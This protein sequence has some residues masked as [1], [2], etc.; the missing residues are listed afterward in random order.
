M[1]A[2]LLLLA[3]NLAW[4][5][6][7]EPE[8][9]REAA[10]RAQAAGDCVEARRIWLD[11][12]AAVGDDLEAWKGIA[13]CR[14]GGDI[15]AF[16]EGTTEAI[17][18]SFILRHVPMALEQLQL[19]ELVPILSR[20]QTQE[21]KGI[22]DYLL[23]T[24]LHRRMN[25]PALAL[26]AMGQAISLKPDDA[27]LRL[28][29]AQL[30][31]EQGQ[32]GEARAAYREAVGAAAHAPRLALVYGAAMGWPAPFLLLCLGLAAAALRV[33]LHQ[34]QQ[35]PAPSPLA[36][37]PL[38]GE[39]HALVEAHAMDPRHQRQI[40]GLALLVGLVC[41]VEFWIAGQRV[42][43]VALLAAGSAGGLWLASVPLRRPLTRL[44]LDSAKLVGAVATGRIYRRLSRI[45]LWGQ[46]AVLLACAL[47]VVFVTPRVEQG[48]LRLAALFLLSMLFFASL[49]SLMLTV[50]AQSASL[51]SSLRG[52]AIAGTLPFLVLFLYLERRSL[53]HLVASGA[54]LDPL[55][56]ERALAY[57][58]VWGTA[59][60]LALMM[61][62]ILSRSI[63]DPLSAIDAAVQRVRAGD[64]QARPEVSRRDEIGALATAVGDMAEGLAQRE[65]IK[66][67]FRRYVD[68]RVAEH[69]MADEAGMK[70]GRRRHAAV[71]F[72]DVRGFTSLSEQV[73]PEVVVQVLN[74]VFTRLTPVVARWGGVVDKFIGDAMMAVWGVPEPVREG[75]LA[76]LPLEVL[77][78]EA[79][80]DMLTA[81]D[82]L[83][84]ELAARDLPQL[85]LG[86]GVNSGRVIAG[87]IGS[88]ERQEYTVIGDVVNT[89]QRAEGAARDLGRLLVTEAIVDAVGER[90]ELVEVEAQT[91]K[92][93]AGKVRLWRVEGRR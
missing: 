91:L 65:R 1:L 67:T 36:S 16:L 82:A 77:A 10:R 83:N 28:E 57:L 69:L 50:L 25:N 74:E 11:L 58:I 38:V 62:R 14:S 9:L 44:G 47:A 86:I 2:W 41:A 51:R 21:Q 89:A 39:A 66:A 55:A 34:L 3:L 24:E 68:A 20:V 35:V 29:F 84:E 61:A 78:V 92:G 88:A 23:L 63:L 5:G 6:P 31:F 75:P 15:D 59:T 53:A 52:I 46:A 4:A 42:A 76:A 93:K 7:A 17:E 60:G 71:L 40:L 73:E 81:L 48:D 56:W 43:F 13:Q 79:A 87:P 64:F 27:G 8:A 70:Q 80:L 33:K 32:V 26:Q 54:I 90:F 30:L 49:G 18:Q 85:Q 37:L 72:S 45:P 19:K 12:I 22:A